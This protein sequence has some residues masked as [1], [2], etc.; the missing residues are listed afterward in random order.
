MDE[1]M[2]P[3]VLFIGFF[4]TMSFISH[5]RSK[6]SAVATA[7]RAEVY[8]RM[9]DKFGSAK[10]FTDF[11]Q[12]AE[13]R[14]FIEELGRDRGPVSGPYDKILWSIKAGVLSTL[15]GLTLV[16]LSMTMFD[17]TEEGVMIPGAILTA[18]GAGF[19][20]SAVISQRLSASWGILPATRVER[21]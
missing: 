1:V 16:L 2:I 13:G 17:T 12:T 7:A 15:V 9:I 10:E 18:L 3:I 11:L 21:A 8:N 14:S 4:A 6:R 19:I 5:N 20:I